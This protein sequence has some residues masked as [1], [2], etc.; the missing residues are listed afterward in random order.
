MSQSTVAKRYAQA[1]F[2]VAQNNNVLAEVSADLKELLSVVANNNELFALLN[3]PKLSVARKKEMVSEIFASANPIVVNAV[4]VLIEKKRVNDIET[5]ASNFLELA[6]AAQGSANA[7][8]YSTRALSTEETAEISAAFGK[9]VGKQSLEITNEIDASLIGGVR[10]Q[11][12]NYI[13]D[14]TVA[15][16]LEGLKRTLVG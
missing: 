13:F 14:N 5:V 10:V 16:K 8:V 15:S 1:L 3:A 12:G 11:I 6:A 4:K 2:E 7:I 9:L